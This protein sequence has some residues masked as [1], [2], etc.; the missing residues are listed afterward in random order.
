MVALTWLVLWHL[1]RYPNC[2]DPVEL[3]SLLLR[4]VLFKS[5]GS[6]HYFHTILGWIGISLICFILRYKEETPCECAGPIFAGRVTEVFCA[7]LLLPFGFYA[8]KG[9]R[10][11]S[12]M[13][14]GFSHDIST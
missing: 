5:S 10:P 3:V 4:H 13:A 14:F 8:G 2:S 9:E 7:G 6:P 1:L 11:K 12:L